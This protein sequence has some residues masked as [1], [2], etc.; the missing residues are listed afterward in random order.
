M[1]AEE[2]K[3]GV[4]GLMAYLRDPEVIEILREEVLRP[5]IVPIVH[6]AVT[7]AVAE[8]DAEIERLKTEIAH[9]KS[10]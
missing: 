8:R 5:L 3:E 6:Q 2:V 10:S 7:D 1:S 9:Q 4:K